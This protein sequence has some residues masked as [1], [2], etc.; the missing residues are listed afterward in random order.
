MRKIEVNTETFQ[1]LQKAFGISRVTLWRALNYKSNT[2]RAQKIRSIAMQKGGQVWTVDDHQMDTVFDS[3]GI[4]R[5]YFG[6]RISLVV[7]RSNHV[8]VYIDG[9]VKEEHDSLSIAQLMKLQHR[10]TVLAASI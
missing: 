2:D 7:D 8:T 5:Q 3:D 1:F 6:D 10:M 9:E 4:M